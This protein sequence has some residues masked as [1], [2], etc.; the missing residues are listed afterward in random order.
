MTNETIQSALDNLERVIN[1]TSDQ[2]DLLLS[3]LT[4]TGMSSISGSLDNTPFISQIQILTSKTL[5]IKSEVES[6][7][8]LLGIGEKI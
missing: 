2:A 5:R 6:C 4:N 3:K 1:L 8:R 7:I